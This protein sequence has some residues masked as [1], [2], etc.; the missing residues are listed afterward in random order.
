MEVEVYLKQ[1]RF[2]PVV[3]CEE[4]GIITRSWFSSNAN[5]LKMQ[6]KRIYKILTHI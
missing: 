1:E 6:F 5:M 2:L 4:I 3:K